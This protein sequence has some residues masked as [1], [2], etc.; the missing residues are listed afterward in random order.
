MSSIREGGGGGGHALAF[1]VMRLCR[2]ALQ[3]DL[4]LCCD[5]RDL[6]AGED[7]DDDDDGGGGLGSSSRALAGGAAVI[8]GGGGG[9]GVFARRYELREPVEALGL[10]GMLVLPQAFGSIYLGE[11]FCSYISIGNHANVDVHNVVIKAELQ[12]EK[13]RAVLADNAKA[14]IERLPPGGRHDFIIEHDIK[15]LGSHTSHARLTTEQALLYRLVCSAVYTDKEGERKHLPQFFKFMASNPLSVRTKVRTIQDSVFLEA[16]IENCTKSPFFVDHVR[17]DPTGSWTVRS[18]GAE[19]EATRPCASHHSRSKRWHSKLLQKVKLVQA[20]GGSQHFLYHIQRAREGTP[21]ADIGSTLGRLE[22]MWRTTL[23]EPGRLQTQP[24]LASSQA[25]RKEVE[26]KLVEMPRRVVL[27]QPFL[28]GGAALN[29]A[30]NQVHCKV[31][32]MTDRRIGPLVISMPPAAGAPVVVHGPWTMN[33]PEMQHHFSLDVN[34][35]FVALAVGVQKIQGVSVAD[36]EDGKPYDSLTVVEDNF[37]NV[38]EMT[39]T[40]ADSV[41]NLTYAAAL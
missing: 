32:N 41:G 26:L 11:T 8:G 14:P 12:T 10:G 4:P 20:N 21:R 17:F 35:C 16:S 29:D 30:E 15:E 27:E 39:H 40:A 22:I 33:I 13:Q 5:P 18:L 28:V 37:K 6:C 3:V 19:T 7:D 2:P 23:G 9:G 36:L 25:A 1:R 24:I 38:M 34:L 31:S